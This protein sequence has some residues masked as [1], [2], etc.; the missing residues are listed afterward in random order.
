MP[1]ILEKGKPYPLLWKNS[2]GQKF[3]LHCDIV[4]KQSSY[5]NIVGPRRLSTP[6]KLLAVVPSQHPVLR[7]KP[8]QHSFLN[9]FS[10]LI[11]NIDGDYQTFGMNTFI[12]TLKLS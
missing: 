5:D 2:D 3:L 4:E 12:I 6:S 7:M 11:T 9:D 1:E 10:L 8:H